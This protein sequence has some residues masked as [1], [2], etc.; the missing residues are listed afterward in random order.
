MIAENK[1]HH[2]ENISEKRVKN[3]K[4]TVE[5]DGTAYHGWQRQKELPTVQ[6]SIETAIHTMTGETVS[7]IGAGRTDAGVHAL[8][9]VANFRIKSRLT[10][11]VFFKGLNS[12]LPPDIVIKRCE[13]VDESFH[14]RFDAKSKVYH[15]RILNRAAPIAISRQ[16]VWHIWKPLDLDAIEDSLPFLTGRHDFS[17]FEGSGSERKSPIRTVHNI[18]MRIIDDDYLIFSIEADGFLKFMVRNIVGTLVYVGLGKIKPSEIKGILES[19]DRRRAGVTAPAH[20]L[21]L[22]LIRY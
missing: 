19:K 15:Y 20:G 14:S 2:K 11:D 9:Q 12:L 10:P 17:A 1:P 16:Y 7:L 21:F 8:N 6:G 18:D 13:E 22:M 3:I 5:Y 4:I